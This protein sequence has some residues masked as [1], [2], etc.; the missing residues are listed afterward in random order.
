MKNP[1][2]VAGG[3]DPSGGAGLSADIKTASFF[4]TLPLPIITAITYQNST[5]FL[6][7]DP[8]STD[9]IEKQLKSVISEYDIQYAKVGMTGSASNLYKLLTILNDKNIKIILDP[10]MTPSAGGSVLSD[11]MLTVLKE[12]LNKVYLITPNIPEALTITGL[13]TENIVE[14]GKEFLKYKQ[15]AVLIK[16]GHNKG[17]SSDFLFEKEIKTVITGNRLNTENLR[18]TGCTL[19]TAI[20]A[21]LASG[22]EL[23]QAC[24]IAKQYVEST[25]NHE[26][27]VGKPPFPLNHLLV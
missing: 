20:T 3:L 9:K 10:V 5:N 26:Y 17:D 11:S 12:N 21:V 7:F 27:R 14:L 15:K 6:G 1:I 22:I 2:I 18:G 16:G 19:S 23:Q 24:K 4:R 25:M 13:D 8:V